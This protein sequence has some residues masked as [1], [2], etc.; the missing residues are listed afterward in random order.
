MGVTSGIPL[1]LILSTL[2][3]W[4]TREDIDISTIGLFAL[5]QIPW[6][7]KFLWAPIIDSFRIPLLHRLLGQRKAWLFII[8]INLILFIILLGYSNP[9]ENL[10]LTALLALIISFFSASQ[11]VVIDAY[12]IEILNDDSQGAGAAMTQFGYR[13]GGLFAGAGSLY[14][15]VIFSWEYVFLTISIIF[16]FLMV[17]IIFIIPSTN[18]HIASKKNLIEPF[19]EFLFRNSISKVS[20]IF[21][22]IFFFKFGDVIAGVM[23][24]PFYVKIG[25]S[26][27]EI[28]NASKVFGVIMTILGVFIGGYFVKIF[29][30]LK[31]LLISGFFQVFSNLLYVLLNYMGPELSYL[32]LTVA[33]ENFSGGLGSAAFVAYLSSLCNRKYTGTQYALL[34]SIMGLARAILSSPSG[35]LVEYIGWSKFFIISTFLGLPSII[36]LFWMFKMFPLKDQKSMR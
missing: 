24:N 19:R 27:I 22:F 10:K 35:Y 34:S 11:D 21:L 5:T 32:F 23:A 9:T 18:S 26:N 31:S 33:G 17:F 15:T 1:Y 4:L 16:F 29:G 8:Q 28:A 6:S 12:R 14:L 7:I 20:L 13:V 36:I 30:I 2:F 25:F 3:I